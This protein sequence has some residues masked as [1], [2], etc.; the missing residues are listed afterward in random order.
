[1]LLSTLHCAL[2]TKKGVI[3]LIQ[4][5]IAE[6]ENLTLSVFRAADQAEDALLRLRNLTAQ[7][8][9]D[10]ELMN[11]PQSVD[12]IDCADHAADTL[13]RAT[14]SLKA[15]RTALQSVPDTYRQQEHSHRNALN[16]M[17]GIM[18]SVSVGYHAAITATNLR[19]VEHEDPAAPH[20]NV[21]Q[22]VAGD[23]EEMQVANIAA[24]AKL[25]KKEYGISH[26]RVT[27]ADPVD[28][29]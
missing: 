29:L 25:V 21:Q 16:R 11:Y 6:L 18:D 5:D 9:E 4:V 20:N 24:A 26:I 23:A 8:R 12:A 10:L 19:P 3:V 1:M 15:L 28:A 2:C 17:L 7:M 14:D 22:L 13:G 27:D